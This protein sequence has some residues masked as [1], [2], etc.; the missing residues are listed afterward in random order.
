VALASVAG[1]L[2]LAGAAG[3]VPDDLDLYQFRF[4]HR[5]CRQKGSEPGLAGLA[6]APR[7]TRRQ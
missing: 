1:L 7:G 4:E 5:A 6:L 2:V 3:G